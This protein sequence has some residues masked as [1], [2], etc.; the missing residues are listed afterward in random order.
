MILSASPYSRDPVMVRLLLFMLLSKANCRKPPMNCF[1]AVSLGSLL[2][3]WAQLF[4]SPP[5]DSLSS[6]TH[7]E[8]T[9]RNQR[10]TP[11]TTTSY[12][13][14]ETAIYK[15]TNPKTVPDSKEASASSN[16]LH[17][18]SGEIPS[19]TP[20]SLHGISAPAMHLTDVLVRVC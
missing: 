13:R 7:G 20:L 16:F 5:D 17:P 9:A 11:D 18:Q 3:G 2:L 6:W 8:E 14:T 10:A 19:S 1:S 15:I 12:T 4:L